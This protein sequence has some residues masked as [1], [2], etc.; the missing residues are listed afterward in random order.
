MSLINTDFD[1]E[2]FLKAPVKSGTGPGPTGQKAQTPDKF[3]QSDKIFMDKMDIR[4]GSIKE[5]TF[6]IIFGL[7]EFKLPLPGEQLRI[8]TQ[9]QLNLISLLLKIVEK[10]EIA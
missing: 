10:N 4:H 6:K 7:F 5:S 3:K 1:I 9:R 2:K 8:R